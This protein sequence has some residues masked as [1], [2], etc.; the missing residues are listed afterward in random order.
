M[1]GEQRPLFAYSYQLIDDVGGDGDGVIERGE[2]VRVRV[3]VKNLGMGKAYD[4]WTTLKNGAGQ[5]GIFIDKGRFGLGSIPSG[6]TKSA[7]FIL[8][9][10]PEYQGDSFSTELSVY[11]GVLREYVSEKLKFPVS[12]QRQ[13]SA[14]LAATGF[15]AVAV[16]HAL[17]RTAPAVTASIVGEANKGAIFE[18]LGKVST[19]G[20][21]FLRVTAQPGRPAFVAEKDASPP[22]PNLA[23]P[24]HDGF[25]PRWQVSPPVLTLA[26][27]A[28]EV[29]TP[30]YTLAGSAKADR[31]VQ[32][33]F[34]FVNNSDA[35]INGRKVFYTSNRNAKDSTTLPFNAQIPLWPG[36]N[37]VTVV[38]RENDEVQ[39][40]QTLIVF[41]RD[42]ST[43]A[44][45]AP[46]GRGKNAN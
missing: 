31:R 33:L 35:K 34:V 19:P 18:L 1:Q 4:T 15:V 17:F 22:F 46:A 32:D 40:R 39:S 29:T 27:G 41:R 3:S 13:N 25:V 11:D 43:A 12:A 42:A 44:V 14:P 8:D 7:D 45:V 36:V 26:S 38:A 30:T 6:T 20:G 21:T 9:V 24:A 23:A 2:K 5:E 10:K 16:D 37:H 28:L